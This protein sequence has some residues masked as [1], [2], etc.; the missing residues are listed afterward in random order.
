MREWGGSALLSCY[1]LCCLW[2]V[3]P[4]GPISP[5]PGHRLA[6]GSRAWNGLEEIP[7]SLLVGLAPRP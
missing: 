1:R 5:E 6:R 3:V 4:P 7:T 2:E